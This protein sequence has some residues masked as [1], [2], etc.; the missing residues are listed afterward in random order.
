[1]AFK[2]CISFFGSVGKFERVAGRVLSRKHEPLAGVHVRLERIT[3]EVHH[4]G[5]TDNDTEDS[6]P[7]ITDTEGAYG[8]DPIG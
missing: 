4:P 3:L 8:P 1:V 7:V 6:T 5:G 2:L